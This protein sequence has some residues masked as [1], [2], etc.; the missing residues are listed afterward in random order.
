[1]EY[2][3]GKIIEQI[4]DERMAAVHQKLNWIMKAMSDSNVMPKEEKEQ[5]HQNASDN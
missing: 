5:K 1:M 3:E 4:I 2:S